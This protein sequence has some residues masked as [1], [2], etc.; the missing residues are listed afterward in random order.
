MPT[1]PHSRRGTAGTGGR[2]GPALTQRRHHSM[3]DTGSG[4]DPDVPGEGEPTERDEQRA[5]RV[6]AARERFTALARLADAEIDLAEAALLIAAEEFPD[7]DL[8][9]YVRELDRPGERV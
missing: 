2:H 5:A 6:S 9:H 3:A 8:Q 4:D 7:L 1:A